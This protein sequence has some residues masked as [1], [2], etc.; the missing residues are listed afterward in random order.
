MSEEENSGEDEFLSLPDGDEEDGKRGK[1]RKKVVT[2][3]FVNLIMTF[4]M[5]FIYH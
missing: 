2:K 5:L 1:K 4:K 3:R